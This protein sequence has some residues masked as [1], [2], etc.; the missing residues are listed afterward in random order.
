LE[1]SRHIQNFVQIIEP[2][3]NKELCEFLHT[4]IKLELY[5]I[6]RMTESVEQKL[7]HLMRK[8]WRERWTDLMW[9]IYVKEVLQHS[10]KINI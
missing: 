1:I 7:K 2:C 9:G 6:E 5:L 4:S 3:F 8:A 10:F